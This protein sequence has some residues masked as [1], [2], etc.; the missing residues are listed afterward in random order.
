MVDMGTRKERMTWE[1][2]GTG[3]VGQDPVKW[4][5]FQA[6]VDACVRKH[7]RP[8]A[9]YEDVPVQVILV[10]RTKY[11]RLVDLPIPKTFTDRSKA[12]YAEALKKLTTH[13]TIYSEA[14]RTLA[15]DHDGHLL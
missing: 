5:A 7:F 4:A 12:T 1:A 6:D 14:L 13:L 8:G 2:K 15:R 3:I 11:E 9:G 10:D